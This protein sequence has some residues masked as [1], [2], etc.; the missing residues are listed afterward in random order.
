MLIVVTYDVSTE[1]EKGRK[2]LREVAK[3]CQNFGQR[4]QNSVFE[5]QV[6]KI[7]LH[8]LR[9]NLLRVYKEEEDSLRLYRITEPLE[10]NIEEYGKNKSID[11]EKP[12]IV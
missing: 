4:V 6:S 3:I 1:D 11:F 9:T 10:S 2:R 5:C 7:E 8:K 12:L